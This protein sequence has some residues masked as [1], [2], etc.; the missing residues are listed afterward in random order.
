MSE[1]HQ[2]PS[3][4]PT[5]PT[6]SS[7]GQ[8]SGAPTSTPPPT[9]ESWREQRRE[10]RWQGRAGRHQSWIGGAVLVGLGVVFL[11][12]NLGAPAELVGAVHPD[13]RCP[14]FRRRLAKLPER[15]AAD[16]GRRR[17]AGRGRDVD[18]PGLGL[19]AEPG[20]GRVLA[21]TAHSGRPGLAG[22]GDG[23]GVAGV[24]APRR[25]IAGSHK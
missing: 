9:V 14:V 21:G 24:P 20:P 2:E 5:S 23:E 7:G 6:D 10:A 13:P 16:A 3:V 19:S 15:R 17:L 8:P 22:D 18:H 11:A 4:D 12:Q 1:Q 25:F